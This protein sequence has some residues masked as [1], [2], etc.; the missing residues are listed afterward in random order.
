MTTSTVMS[1]EQ[2]GTHKRRVRNY[3]LDS[4]FQLKYAGFLVLVAIVISGVVGAVLYATTLSMVRESS[5]VVEESR[6]AVQ[7]SRNV[8]A[9]S[10]MNVHDLALDS[11]ELVAEFNKE[12]DAVDS[13]MAGHQKVVVAQQESLVRRQRWMLGSLVAALAVMVVLIGLLG[14]LFTH[15]VAGPV[16]KMSRLLAQ[17]GKGNLQVDARLRRGDELKAFFDTFT[18]MVSGL[19][20]FERRQLA[21]VEAAA[22]ALDRGDKEDAARAIQQVRSAIRAAIGEK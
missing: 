4:R 20:E 2:A 9:V 18:Q 15:K 22:K 19:R 17:V 16:F 5:K 14:I 12:A 10:R 6:N 7:E 3:L 1:S 21:D 13:A 11:P 8:S